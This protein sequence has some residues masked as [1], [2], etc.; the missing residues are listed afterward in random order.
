M[1]KPFESLEKVIFDATNHGLVIV[2]SDYVITDVNSWFVDAVNFDKSALCGQSLFDMFDFRQ[3]DFL[4][5]TIDQA[6]KSGLSSFLSS[7]LHPRLFPLVNRYQN[8]NRNMEHSCSI[9]PIEFN[10]QTHCLFQIQDISSTIV[11]EDLLH[12]TSNTL[13]LFRIAMEH[14]KSSIVITN[15]QGIIEYVNPKF[16]DIAGFT[17]EDAIGH[18]YF[19]LSSLAHEQQFESQVLDTLKNKDSWHGE[20][21]FVTKSGVRYWVNENIYQAR[22]TNNSPSHLVAIQDDLTQIKDIARKAN[23]QA[24][25][26]SLTGLINR[27]AFES[28]LVENIEQAQDTPDHVLCFLDIDQFKIINDISGHGA[29]DELLRQIAVVIDEHYPLDKVL[30]RL[31]GD[32]FAVV[33]FHSN[34]QTAQQYGVDLIEKLHDFKFRWNDSVFSIGVS[35]GITLIDEEMSSSRDAIK[36][37]ENA[38]DTAKD[39]GRNCVYHY[40]EDDKALVQRQGDTYWATK[41][42]DALEHGSF[43]LFAQSILPLQQTSLASYEV[44]VRMRDTDGSVIPPGMFLPAAER[45]HLSH[46][47]DRWVI[48]NTVAWMVKHRD[49]IAHI[50]HISINL[51]GLTLSNEALLNHILTTVTNSNIEPSKICFE[52]TE[53]AAIAN[54]VQAKHFIS[55]L[56]EYGCQFALDDFGSGLSSFAYLKNLK[57]DLLKID[58]M[59]VKDIVTDPIDE[60]MVK[61]INDVGHVMGMETIAEFVEDE[62]IK[63]RLIELGIDYGQG[64]GLG[65]PVPI[66]DILVNS[67]QIA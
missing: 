37:A 21:S 11:R 59:F 50:H 34:A 65:K 53:T 67:T 15:N 54:I 36:Q 2:D 12:K 13:S 9:K 24:S 7:T 23:Y 32:E 43:L 29:G 14:S 45:F 52:I 4:Q 64:Y 63:K 28:I 42:N 61:S 49:S 40:Q 39:M 35:I 44:L 38:C 51:S 5:R 33:L 3:A 19:S 6:C 56:R 46:R 16:V 10:G 8:C 26:D 17:S 30:A 57:V 47:V 55:V 31:G 20:R 18:S 22:N 60:A 41:I 48:D 27:K 62:S 66:D 1:E 58:G 25:H